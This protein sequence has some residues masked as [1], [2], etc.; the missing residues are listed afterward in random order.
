MK[1]FKWCNTAAFAAVL[2]VNA[3]A[4]LLPIGGKTTGEISEQYANLFTPAGY[5]FAIWGLIYLLLGIFVVYGWGL[6]GD[7]APGTVLGQIG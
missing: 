6:V 7:K 1:L 5:T 2:A 3:L 4:N